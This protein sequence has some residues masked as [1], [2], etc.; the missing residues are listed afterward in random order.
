LHGFSAVNGFVW[1]RDGEQL[2]FMQATPPRLGV[3]RADGGGL[4]RFNR[5]RL[6][7]RPLAWSPDGRRLAYSK[8]FID[9]EIYVRQIFGPSRER[10][11]T[12]EIDQNYFGDV[13][14]RAGLISYIVFE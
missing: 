9:K 1:S 3:V 6:R 8:G 4:R 11:V 14:W 7:A 12:N 5:M 10:R 2:A 13:R